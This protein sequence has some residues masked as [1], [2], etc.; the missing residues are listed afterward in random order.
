MFQLHSDS[1]IRKCEDFGEME[2][3]TVRDSLVMKCIIVAFMK[4]EGLQLSLSDIGECDSLIASRSTINILDQ[5]LDNYLSMV[6]VNNKNFDRKT[7]L[8]SN[9]V[10]DITP[11]PIQNQSNMKVEDINSSSIFRSYLETGMPVTRLENQEMKEDGETFSEDKIASEPLL[12]RIFQCDQCARTFKTSS[13]RS[14]HFYRTHFQRE[15]NYQCSMCAKVFIYLSD[16]V[17]HSESH[18]NNSNHQCL[19]CNK[20]FKYEKNLQAHLKKHISPRPYLCNE[21]GR[22]F[23]KT[24]TLNDHVRKFH[25]G[26]KETYKCDVCSKCFN[27]KSNLSRHIRSIH[28]SQELT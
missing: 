26:V 12:D 19:T 24:S 11:S 4:T 5:L 22:A 28:G 16:L 27:V 7:S 21:C 10:T 23:S 17:K 6:S 9:E 25:E 15:T 3:L 2:Q 13:S 20:V 8:A 1:L 18:E 14:A